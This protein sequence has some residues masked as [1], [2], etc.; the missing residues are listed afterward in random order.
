MTQTQITIALAV[1]IGIVI[2]R[3]CLRSPS[4]NVASPMRAR[5]G[6][7]GSP[8]LWLV[9]LAVVLYFLW[10]HL[11]TLLPALMKQLSTITHASSSTVHSMTTHTTAMVHS[12]SSYM[13]LARQDAL[14]AGIDPDQFVRQINE[15]SGFNPTIVSPKGAIGIA[16]IMPDTA[17]GWN[18]NPW[19]PIDALRA[20]AVH[21]AAYARAYGG[22]QAM[23]LAAYNAGTGGV[24]SAV[25]A[26]GT[27]W[28]A[29]LPQETQAY[30]RVIL[31]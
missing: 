9:V 3:W 22:N 25:R 11:G 20:A 17:K 28:Q 30:I 15:E 13:T 18:V 5:S 10:P 2:V 23:A 24:E 14:S 26:C 19:N 21:M 6:R 1:V 4:R 31:S 12:S 7:S 29:C 16:Q 8:L 27:N